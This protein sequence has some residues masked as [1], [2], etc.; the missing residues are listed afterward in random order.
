[1]SLILKWFPPS[2]VQLKTPKAVCYID[3]SYMRTNYAKHPT[4]IE[5][6]TWPGP[7]RWARKVCD[8]EILLIQP[9]NHLWTV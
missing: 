9:K 8:K 5:F 4:K 2:W 6:S 3:P 1:M 7:H